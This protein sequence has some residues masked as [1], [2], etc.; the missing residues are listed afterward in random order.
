MGGTHRNKKRNYVKAPG[1]KNATEPTILLTAVT[2]KETP[3]EL[4]LTRQASF[5]VKHEPPVYVV[6]ETKTDIAFVYD[7]MKAGIVLVFI[8]IIAP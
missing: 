1:L 5:L 8:V 3:P 6:C 4:L 2:R 7:A